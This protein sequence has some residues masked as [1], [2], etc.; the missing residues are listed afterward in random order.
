MR[1]I[2]PEHNWFWQQGYKDGLAGARRDPP[3]EARRLFE[4]SDYSRGY[5]AGTERPRR[6]K[7]NPTTAISE[8]A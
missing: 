1:E 5:D 2:D 7:R 4:R 8:K 3:D 6:K